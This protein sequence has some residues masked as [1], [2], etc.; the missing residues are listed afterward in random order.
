MLRWFTL[1]PLKEA[2]GLRAKRPLLNL[3]YLLKARAC[4]SSRPTRAARRR[5]VSP[6]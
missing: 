3:E 1:R 6:R 5:L 4:F 2:L